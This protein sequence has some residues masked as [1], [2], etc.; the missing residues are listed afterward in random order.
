MGIERKRSPARQQHYND[1]PAASFTATSSSSSS[2]ARHHTV[3]IR[4][5]TLPP[6]GRS[7]SP[8]ASAYF[9]NFAQDDAYAPRPTADA[10]A[11]FAYSTTLRRHH[12]EGP[13]AFPQSPPGPTFPRFDDLRNTIA[14]EGPTG[15][16]DRFVHFLKEFWPGG[17]EAE[18]QPV[19]TRREER[20]DTPSARFAHFS[21]EVRRSSDIP[22]I[23]CH[24]RPHPHLLKL[25]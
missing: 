10:S 19:V 4:A 20:K 2:F 5:A 6:P 14:E 9:S 24:A 13:L 11:H 22:V 12:P 1:P 18:Y 7:D 3:N 16:W 21:A 8:P 23:G 17:A 25:S 15:V